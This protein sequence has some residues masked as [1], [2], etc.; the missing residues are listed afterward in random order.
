MDLSK[1]LDKIKQQHVNFQ[2]TLTKVEVSRSTLK[3]T[4]TSNS[5]SAKKPQAPAPSSAK[6][7]QPQL[8]F[9]N[10]TERLQHINSIRKSAVGAQI[11]RVIDLLFEVARVSLRFF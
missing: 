10:D 8:K 2:N 5:S 4:T 1:K 7:P 9:S 11:K 6:Q 3:N